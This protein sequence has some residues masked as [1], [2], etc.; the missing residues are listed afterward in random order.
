MDTNTPEMGTGTAV[1]AQVDIKSLLDSENTTTE[2]VDADTGTE[3]VQNTDDTDL[4]EDAEQS[5]EDSEGVDDDAVEDS[6]AEETDAAP[7]NTFKDENL[8]TIDGEQ[9][10]FA[11]LKKQ[12]LLHADYTRKRQQETAELKQHMN[13]YQVQQT[14]MDQMRVA[15]AND[16]AEMKRRI[17]AVIDPDELQK[18]DP[19]LYDVDPY[20]H[21]KKMIEWERK[22]N[23]IRELHVA[24]EQLAQQNAKWAE[25]Q[26]ALKQAEA[27]EQFS[28]KYSEFADKQKA[29][30]LLSELGSFLSENGFGREEIEG[31]ADSR[32][33]D[34][35][36][37]LYKAETVSKQVPKVV[38]EINNRAKLA[39]PGTAT[40]KSPKKSAVEINMR[41]Y[42][43]TG[44]SEYSTAAIRD[45]LDS[46]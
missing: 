21:G 28:G 35:V 17:V 19:A 37:R 45:L 11:E 3:E 26:H 9:I 34:I 18:P 20:L 8:V 13:R 42:R 14:D 24:E 4:V 5:L 10:S 39:M 31:I 7:E 41:K 29:P 40:N 16:V 2:I 27:M 30:A 44:S 46:E 43:E 12:R 38:A 33:M 23:A 22:Q 25:E 1:E 15:V 6:E 32:I 36:Y